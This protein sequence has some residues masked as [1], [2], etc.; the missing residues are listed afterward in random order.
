MKPLARW[1]LLFPAVVLGIAISW[2]LYQ[3]G[4]AV[5]L[6]KCP[7]DS[8]HNMA[9]GFHL[10]A[11]TTN[12]QF[13]T[14]PW[15]PATNRELFA[16]TAILSVLVSGLLGFFTAPTHKRLFAALSSLLAVGAACFLA[17]GV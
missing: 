2:H 9:I 5:A 1:L 12:D 13:C 3:Y 7:K 15:F 17:L 11:I 16:T 8:I 10:T 4:V 6:S 14:A